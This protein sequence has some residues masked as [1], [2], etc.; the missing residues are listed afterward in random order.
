MAPFLLAGILSN[1]GSCVV[2]EYRKYC[3]WL[4]PHSV[5]KV[6]NLLEQ[7]GIRLE[8]EVRI[9]C[10]VLRSS[11][12]IRILTP[13][14]WDGFCKRKTSWYWKSDKAKKLLIVSS[15][16]LECSGLDRPIV[17]H[18]S[19]FQ[20]HRLPLPEEVRLLVQSKEFEKKKPRLW[21][22]VTIAEKDTYQRWLKRFH[23][24]E[25]FDFDRIFMVQ[26]ANHANFLDP[27][28]YTGVGEAVTPYSIAKSAYVCS[29]CLEFFNILGD[30]WR[31]KYVVPCLGA[32]QFARV[33][34]DMYFR[35]ESQRKSDD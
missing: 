23:D 5:N 20:P 10:R 17:I 25:P 8:E 4:N 15:R 9:P 30:Q 22:K 7:E 27:R 2:T 31:V 19:N 6:R 24:Q 21:D 1:T 33:P 3:Y 14:A 12:D 34:Q 26:S 16:P 13:S 28:F 11:H 29:S 18:E 32:V 35:V